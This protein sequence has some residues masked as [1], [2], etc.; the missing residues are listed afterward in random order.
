M[1]AQG[2][3]LPEQQIHAGLFLVC[4]FTFFALCVCAEV[5]FC[6][7]CWVRL[8]LC[9]AVVLFAFALLDCLVLCPLCAGSAY[10]VPRTAHCVL[11]NGTV[12][13]CTVYCVLCTV[14]CSR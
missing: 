4:V 10:W 1:H 3:S 6:V 7:A 8:V 14:H 9:F 2:I 11:F 5:L 12:D 13:M